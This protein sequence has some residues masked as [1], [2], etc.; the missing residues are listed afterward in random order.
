MQPGGPDHNASSPASLLYPAVSPLL[1]DRQSGRGRMDAWI[2]PSIH[3]F[4]PRQATAFLWPPLSCGARA[5]VRELVI[6]LCVTLFVNGDKKKD[7]LRRMRRWRLLHCF[8]LS[9]Y[10]TAWLAS[11]KKQA[12]DIGQAGTR[13]YIKFLE[14]VC[15]FLRSVTHFSHRALQLVMIHKWYVCVREGESAKTMRAQQR[16]T[17]HLDFTS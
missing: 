14:G 11:K 2:N 1:W 6:N 9:Q 17:Q 12:L 10:I 7:R 3:S 8:N 13:T 4:G 16:N 15:R 5:C